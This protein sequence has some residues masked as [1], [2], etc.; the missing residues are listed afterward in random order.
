MWCYETPDL[1]TLCQYMNLEP[2]GDMAQKLLDV[3]ITHQQ[4]RAALNLPTSNFPKIEFC[5]ARAEDNGLN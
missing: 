5:K 3:N 2:S 1:A 4:V